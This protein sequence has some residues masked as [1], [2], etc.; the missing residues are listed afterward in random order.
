MGENT[1]LGTDGV[2]NTSPLVGCVQLVDPIRGWQSLRILTT[3]D[4]AVV[5]DLNDPTSGAVYLP[6][7][8]QNIAIR[9][10]LDSSDA[11]LASVEVYGWP[12]GSSTDSTDGNGAGQLLSTHTFTATAKTADRCGDATADQYATDTLIIDRQGY[13]RI[14]VRS[15]TFNTATVAEFVYRVF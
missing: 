15:I 12:A 13:D 4:D 11:S 6:A 3:D 2:K 14:D 5:T 1:G 7:V 8:G 10:L 9:A